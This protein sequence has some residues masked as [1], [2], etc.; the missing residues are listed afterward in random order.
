M[1]RR[2][3]L[4]LGEVLLFGA[5]RLTKEE[6]EDDNGRFVHYE[7]PYSYKEELE[8]SARCKQRVSRRGASARRKETRVRKRDDKALL[9]I[10]Q[11]VDDAHF[12]KIQNANTVKEAWD[13]LCRCHAGGEKIKKVRLQTSRKQYEMLQMQDDEKITEYFN[14]ILTLTNQMKGC[15][16]KKLD[17]VSIMEKIIR[18]LPKSFDYITVAIEESKDLDKLKIEELQSCL[19]AHEMR[20]RDR[21]IIRLD[22]QALRV[23]HAN[24]DGKKKYKNWKGKPTIQGKWKNDEDDEREDEDDEREGRPNTSDRRI[25]ADHYYK[26]KDKR[27]VECFTCHKMG[28]FSYECW[29]NKGRS[30]KKDHN[31]DAHLAKEESDT[32]PVILM[33]TTSPANYESTSH[34]KPS[35]YLDLGCSNHMTCNREWMVNIDETRKSK[36]R[37]ADNNIL[38]V[39]GIGNVVVKRKN[40]A[41]VIIKNVLLVPEIKCNLLSLGQLV[42]NGF[43]VI[44]GNRGQAEIFNKDKKLVLQTNICKNRTFQITL[45][46]VEMQCMKAV[47]EDEN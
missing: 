32:E 28:H 20:L 27:N 1:A 46:M 45:D 23:Q 40:G 34:V 3:C 16:E 9:I 30:L 15:G 22:D 39:E 29:F 11:C 17:D 24:G 18:S 33:V 12:E 35:W 4:K 10:H 47:T 13:I 43:T 8:Q 21:E 6:F 7:S 5:V 19:E 42:G 37:A 25:N 38:K 14:K 26:K 31:K 44:M 36:V 2:K 41:C